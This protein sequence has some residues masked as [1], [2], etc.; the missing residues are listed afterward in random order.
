MLIH[1]L[2]NCNAKEHAAIKSFLADT[3]NEDNTEKAAS[4]LKLMRKYKSIEHSR[5]TAKYMAG[6]ALKEFYTN[7]SKLPVSKDKKF[8]EDLI[9]YMINRDY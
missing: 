1:L 2:K 6:A 5:S 8:I 3:H 4:I 9:I 7:F